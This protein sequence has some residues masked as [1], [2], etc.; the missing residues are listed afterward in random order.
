M[1]MAK[2]GDLI[3]KHGLYTEPGIVSAKND[4]GTVVIDT[5][6]MQINKY[7]RYS[8]TTGLSEAE[9]LKFNAILDDIYANDDDMQKLNGMQSQIDELKRDPENRNVVQYLKNEQ[10]HLVRKVKQLPRLYNM[11]EGKI[12]TLNGS[13]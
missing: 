9:K 2:I 10:A 8:N 13:E 12:R 1:T 11:D 4:D 5:D 3:P 6:P 7:H